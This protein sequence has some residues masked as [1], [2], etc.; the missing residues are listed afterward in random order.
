MKKNIIITILLILTLGL[1]GYII[2]NKT[3]TKDLSTNKATNQYDEEMLS[4]FSGKYSYETI[5]DVFN[6]IINDFCKGY[7]SFELKKDGTFTY[8]GGETCGSITNMSGKYSISKEKIYLIDKNCDREDYSC[9]PL[10]ELNYTIKNNEVEI[11][12]IDAIT[13][14]K[15]IYEKN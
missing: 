12:F 11:Y 4:K 2:Y 6:S 5:Y 9:S 8:E 13:N 14:E 10:E 3:N 15:T 7:T 1:S